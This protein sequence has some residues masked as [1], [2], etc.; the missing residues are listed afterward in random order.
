MIN[1]INNKPAIKNKET[2]LNACAIEVIIA[3]ITA[4][5]NE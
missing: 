3:T 1:F 2:E 4:K 5:N